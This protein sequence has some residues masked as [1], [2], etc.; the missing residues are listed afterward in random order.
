MTPKEHVAR[1]ESL[2]ERVRRNASKPRR[3]A[4]ASIESPA[5]PVAS[6]SP[7]PVAVAPPTPPPPPPSIPEPPSQ[8]ILLSAPPV[9]ETT[10]VR[11]IDPNAAD[12]DE[13][14]LVEVEELLEEEIVDITDVAEEEAPSGVMPSYEE[15]EPPASSRRPIAA[16][17]SEALAEAAEAV[18]LDEGREIPLKTPPPESG[19]Q[20]APPIGLASPPLPEIEE[21]E[22]VET[23]IISRSQP[24]AAQLG[25]TVDLEPAE[26]LEFELAPPPPLPTPPPP[27]V[28]TPA[29]PPPESVRPEVVA[30]PALAGTAG[31]FVTAAR[32]FKPESFVELLDAS[33]SLE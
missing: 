8:P 19:P 14:H 30:R 24:T 21:E 4:A 7:P 25:A 10:L 2:L 12:M 20:E 13:Q 6:P 16:N 27:R 31:A 15:D 32:T 33:L 22:L 9:E 11:A 18:E 3:A 29:P 26:P 5:P 17:M 1:L 23:D 28:P